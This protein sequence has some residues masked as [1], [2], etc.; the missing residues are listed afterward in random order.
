LQVSGAS[1]DGLT[2]RGASAPLQGR[3]ATCLSISL[4]SLDPPEQ[5]DKVG[6]KG[7]V[8]HM[9]GRG[10]KDVADR[11]QDDILDVFGLVR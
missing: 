2:Q 4:L 7:T 3:A 11:D 5:V 9:R 6:W 10:A 1:C 8:E